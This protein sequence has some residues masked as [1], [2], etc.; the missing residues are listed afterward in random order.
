M[1]SFVP[2]PAPGFG[3]WVRKAVSSK[4]FARPAVPPRHS[5]N[6][7]PFRRTRKSVRPVHEE[8]LAAESQI[9]PWF[10]TRDP[11]AC[12]RPVEAWS[13]GE[14]NDAE[15][16]CTAKTIAAE[17]LARQERVWAD[18]QEENAKAIS[19]DEVRS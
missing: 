13:E 2:P 1:G 19:G 12:A 9:E 11:H 15:E 16:D 3:T 17:G 18:C 6:H 10:A 8:I 14:E 4:A 7:R 5:P